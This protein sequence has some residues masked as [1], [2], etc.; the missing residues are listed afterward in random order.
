[1]YIEIIASDDLNLCPPAIAARSRILIHL[2]FS[3]SYSEIKVT[4]YQYN[5][6]LTILEFGTLVADNNFFPN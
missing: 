6:Q 4:T 1:M 2:M 3:Q 5:N